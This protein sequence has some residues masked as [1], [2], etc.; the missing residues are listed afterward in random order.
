MHSLAAQ[1]DPTFDDSEPIVYVPR[2]GEREDPAVAYLRRHQRKGGAKGNVAID[3]A[4]V[5][6]L[7]AIQFS[8][9]MTNTTGGTVVL[10]WDARGVFERFN[11]E[12]NNLSRG[13]VRGHETG[14]VLEGLRAGEFKF[15]IQGV[16]LQGRTTKLDLLFEVLPTSPISLNITNWLAFG[17]S[18]C[19]DP[20]EFADG[21]GTLIVNWR[22][23]APINTPVEHFD[24][25]VNNER[26]EV[27]DGT[28]TSAKIVGLCP[29]CYRVE[30]QAFTPDY[31]S[32]PARVCTTGQI[33]PG[34][35]EARCHGTHANAD[36]RIDAIRIGFHF[37]DLFHYDAAA[38]WLYNPDGGNTFLG[39]AP[40][41]IGEITIRGLDLPCQ[42]Y[43]LEIAGARFVRNEEICSEFR[44]D[45]NRDQRPDLAVNE[46]TRACPN[47][48]G[49]P[50][51]VDMG[52]NP[53]AP[54]F[55]RR[56]QLFTNRPGNANSRVVVACDPRVNQDGTSA[57]AVKTQEI[58]R[59]RR[60]DVNVDGRVDIVDP[61]AALF[62]M[63]GKG[64]AD[65][66]ARF[67]CPEAA[68]V[69]NNSRIDVTDPVRIL[70]TLFL[71]ENLIDA[72]G[73][74]RCGVDLSDGPD[75]GCVY[76]EDAACATVVPPVEPEVDAAR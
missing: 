45:F 23:L 52:G 43:R 51:A 47:L 18:R 39:F 36:G 26:F 61:L 53:N 9:P 34:P 28:K 62:R 21:T 4:K 50:V 11:V 37:S 15:S 20:A 60:G 73:P 19:P 10:T 6:N 25:F 59:F 12:V 68:D 14:V 75:L 72:P 63:F 58:S 1:E 16:T 35:V 65:M 44:S 24:V 38:F 76:P 30:V 67:E 8:Y 32:D 71:G 3:N 40:P 55:T 7:D 70:K 13:A 33:L 56:L 5:V 31:V 17:F 54:E 49:P 22:T 41:D 66:N 42:P 48:A 69:D 74:H 64:L 46:F 29:N 2:G 57:C 27:P